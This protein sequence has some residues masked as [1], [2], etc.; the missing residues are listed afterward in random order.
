MD[1][2][3]SLKGY[4]ATISPYFENNVMLTRKSLLVSYNKFNSLSILSLEKSTFLITL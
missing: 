2:F 1:S 4:P 3:N